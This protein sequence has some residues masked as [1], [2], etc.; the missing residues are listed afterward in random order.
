MSGQYI[1][2]I[3]RFGAWI[4]TYTT[5]SM[6]ILCLCECIS[7]SADDTIHCGYRLLLVCAMSLICIVEFFYISTDRAGQS[8][9]VRTSLKIAL[10][11]SD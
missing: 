1:R 5:Y 6:C 4:F 7:R 2:R 10:R 8:G 3:N 11:G 9:F